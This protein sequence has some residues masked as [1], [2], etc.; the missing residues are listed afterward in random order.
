MTIYELNRDTTKLLGIYVEGD[1]FR[2]QDSVWVY[3]DNDIKPFNLNNW[4][5][6]MPL[7]VEHGITLHKYASC[8]GWQAF[9]GSISSLEI[10]VNN[11]NPQIALAEC[12][13]K[14]LQESKP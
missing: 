10:H 3:V 13:L 1:V 4:N 5:D 6:L 12:L 14:V 9:T 11:I 7:V 2:D 8:T